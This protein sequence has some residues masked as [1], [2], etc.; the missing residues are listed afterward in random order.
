MFSFYVLHFYFCLRAPF[1]ER[2][3]CIPS[4]P[5]LLGFLHV[6]FFN[7]YGTGDLTRDQLH[8]LFSGFDFG[9]CLQSGPISFS[10][11]PTSAYRRVCFKVLFGNLRSIPFA[12][13]AMIAAA[14]CGT[15]GAI[16]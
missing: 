4:S 7:Y 16:C 2:F 5:W 14:L 6:F 9:I 8:L 10:S 15:Q 3:A 13:L 12:S 1:L 11:Q